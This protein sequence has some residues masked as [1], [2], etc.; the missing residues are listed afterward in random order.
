MDARSGEWY[1]DRRVTSHFGLWRRIHKPT[2]RSYGIALFLV[3]TSLFLTLLLQRLFPYPFLFLFFA[4][5]IAGAW[6]GGIGPGLFAV[7]LSTLAIDYYF[8]PPIRSLAISAT[9]A[10]YF[11]AFV[12]CALV[13]SWISSAKKR[14]HLA[15]EE[16][17]DQLEVRVAERTNELQRLNTELEKSIRQRQKAQQALIETQSELAHLSRFLTMGELAASIAHE[18]NQPLTAVVTFGN[19]CL[20]WL[21]ASPPNLAEAR[22]AAERIVADGT[23]AS[24]VLSRIRSAFQKQPLS[25]NWFDLN[26]AIA[27]LV[28]LVQHEASRNHIVIRTELAKD[29]PRVKGDRVQIQQV[30]LNLL[31]NAID[32]TRERAAGHGEIVIR[33]AR[34]GAE[35]V[36]VSVE[37][38]GPGFAP[39]IEEKIFEPFFTAKPHGIGMGLS[40][41]RT[42]IESHKG[43]VSAGSKPTG[44]AI[45]EFVL[46]VGS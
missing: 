4:A 29:V 7:L 27:E 39:E 18:V 11:A 44:G 20:Q 16:A 30:V 21:S 42:I 22:L 6:I 23:R 40:I 10:A 46:P 36:R 13:A 25:K 26:D 9:D 28:A 37:D 32:A 24:G 14:D 45:V 38:N 2:A 41:S 1:L 19:A 8:V 15:L 5:V 35:N 12:V 3:G 33:S 34:E 17:R 31:M 43:R